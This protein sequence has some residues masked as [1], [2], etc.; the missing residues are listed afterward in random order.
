MPHAKKNQD[1]QLSID[2]DLVG[3]LGEPSTS[4]SH[5]QLIGQF[6][7]TTLREHMGIVCHYTKRRLNACNIHSTHPRF[8]FILN[9]KCTILTWSFASPQWAGSYAFSAHPTET[10][11]ITWG[12]KGG[13]GT[14]EDRDFTL[15]RWAVF[16]VD[17]IRCDL[18]VFV[19]LVKEKT[20]Y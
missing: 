17:I 14:V 8:V 10:T 16:K 20:A 11:F 19:D 13:Y 3:C 1:E 4:L 5:N 12:K 2:A 6:W 7:R 15:Y 18:S 9:Y